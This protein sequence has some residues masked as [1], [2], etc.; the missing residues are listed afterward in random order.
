MLMLIKGIQK[1]S[2]ID[3]PQKI[4]TTLFVYGCNLRCSYCHNPD[5]ISQEGV[6][7]LKTY[8]EKEVLDFLKKRKGF[9]DGVCISGGEPTLYKELVPFAKKI[10][11]MGFKLKIDTNGTNP[12][13][14]SNL[15]RRKLVD[16]VALDIKA[17]LEKYDAIVNSKVNIESIKESIALVQK[18]KDY[19]FRTTVVPELNSDD[20]I[21]I[22]SLIKGAKAFYLQQFNPKVCLNKA[23][24]KKSTY[25]KE[26]LEKIR[27]SVKNNFDVCEIRT[28]Y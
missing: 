22:A 10:K 1:L 26:E 6:K 25:A 21:K 2:L 8:P 23:Y 19:E 7:K 24:E 20:I 17:P 28:F 4:A 11:S 13:M 3:Y 5:L 9:I 18:L 16:Y 14:L 15:V 12:K 27:N